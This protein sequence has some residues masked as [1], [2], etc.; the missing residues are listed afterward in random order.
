MDPATAT[1]KELSP[2]EVAIVEEGIIEGMAELAK[3]GYPD[4]PEEI[5]V[6]K[7]AKIL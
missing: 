7:M 2:Q 1:I 3:S 5:E 6:C 4:H